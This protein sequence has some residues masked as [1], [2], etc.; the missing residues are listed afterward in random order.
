MRKLIF[1]SALIL[2][3]VNTSC[4]DDEES[5][6]INANLI[7]SWSGTYSGDDRGVWTVNVSA[8]GNVTGTAT[9]SFTSDSADIMGRVNESGSLSATL[10]NS[11]DREFVGQLDENNEAVGTWVD[12]RRGLNGTWE[13]QKN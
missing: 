13:G 11:E 3:L 8:S 1:W 5:E 4:S 6:E 10:G 12:A 9:S 2:T 7:G